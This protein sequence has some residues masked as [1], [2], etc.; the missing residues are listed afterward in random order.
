MKE[1]LSEE[2][3]QMSILKAKARKLTAFKLAVSSAVAVVV[4]TIAGILIAN[5]DVFT[6]LRNTW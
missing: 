2:V 4:V 5:W 3:K 1:W 6:L